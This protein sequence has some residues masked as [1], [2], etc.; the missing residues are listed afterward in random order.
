MLMIPGGFW[1]DREGKAQVTDLSKYTIPMGSL[2]Q[3]GDCSQ[4]PDAILIIFP[5][6]MRLTHSQRRFYHLDL[7]MEETHFQEVS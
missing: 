4:D 2:L 6:R 7:K 5:G 3:P 1:R